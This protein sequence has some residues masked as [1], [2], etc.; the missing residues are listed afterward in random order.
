MND[1]THTSQFDDRAFQAMIDNGFE[2]DFSSAVDDQV[3]AIGSMP[4][5]PSTEGVK[6]LRSLLWS[7][8]DNASSRDLDQIEWAERLLNGDIRVLVGIADVDALVAK[9]SPVDRHAAKNTVTVYTETRIFPMMPENLSTGLT[10]LNEGADRL[11]VVADMTVKENGDVPESTFFRAIVTN[12]AKLAYEDVGDWLEGRTPV[13]EKIAN[14]AG[15]KDQIELQQQAAVRLQK[16]RTAKGASN[17]NRS[18]HQPL[19]KMAR[20]RRSSPLRQTRP[21]S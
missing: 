1:D 13:P 10:S 5:P 2:P 4:V 3:R 17:S 20:S 15:L 9:D 16:Y 7:S 14:T 8:I 18:N 11:A 6:D 21:E 19:L 12:K